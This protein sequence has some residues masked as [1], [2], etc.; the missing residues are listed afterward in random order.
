[1]NHFLL[2]LIVTS[3]GRSPSGFNLM[4]WLEPLTFWELLCDRCGSVSMEL[5]KN[6]IFILKD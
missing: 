6:V 1:M 2:L 5:K 3:W 4:N